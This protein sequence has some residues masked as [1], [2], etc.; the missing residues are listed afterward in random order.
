[1]H[2]TPEKSYLPL[3]QQLPTQSWGP[4]KHPIFENLGGG[5]TPPAERG[6][7]G[8]GCTLC[9]RLYHSTNINEIIYLKLLRGGSGF[10]LTLFFSPVWCRVNT[11]LIITSECFCESFW[12]HLHQDFL[13][14]SH[15]SFYLENHTVVMQLKEHYHWF[16]SFI[17][18]W[19]WF[20]SHL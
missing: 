15:W 18:G 1:M 7:G 4:V 5:S 17:K 13:V 9:L 11:V 3:L 2:P 20:I 16:Y 12:F 19:H 8:G 6:R 10:K 14:W